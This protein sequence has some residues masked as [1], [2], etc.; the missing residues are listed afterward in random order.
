MRERPAGKKVRI[1]AR[2]TRIFED[3]LNRRADT[4]GSLQS[5]HWPGAVTATA[6]RRL[7]VLVA[8]GYLH[9]VVV[10]DI[11][12]ALR[13]PADTTRKDGAPSHNTLAYT[14]T[15][16]ALS[17][18]R[19]RSHLGSV[20]RARHLTTEVHDAAIL[21]QLAVNRVGDML[22]AR[23]TADHLLETSSGQRRHRP[24]ATYH[25]TPDAAGATLVML[26]VDLGHY[27][28][29]RILGKVATFLANPDAKGV[30]LASPTTVRAAWIAR[31]LRDEYG[32]RIMDRV[33]SLSFAQLHSGDLLREDLRPHHTPDGTLEAAYDNLPRAA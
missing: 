6:R 12:P 29:Q 18:L 31:V 26:E 27:S 17:A 3:L 2:D 22:D 9:R 4:L 19:R 15:P 7:G 14:L 16:K 33:Q 23:L 13:H 20:L 8:A 10:E 5:R 21:H 24:D 25:A 11:P 1:T 32:D 28:R 30:L